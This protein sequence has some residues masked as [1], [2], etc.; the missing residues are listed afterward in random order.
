M[1]PSVRT[2]IMDMTSSEGCSLDARRDG[3]A[4]SG[5]S[6]VDSSE[7]LKGKSLLLLR[8]LDVAAGPALLVQAVAMCGKGWGRF[9]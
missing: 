3:S 4:S 9:D 8:S 1:R 5:A 2:W 6:I 7:H